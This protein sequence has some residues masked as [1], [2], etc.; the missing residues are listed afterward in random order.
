MA[1]VCEEVCLPGAS[2]WRGLVEVPG[3]DGHSGGETEGEGQDALL[4]E[5]ALEATETGRKEHVEASQQVH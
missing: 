2:G 5:A 3:D 1:E 4:E